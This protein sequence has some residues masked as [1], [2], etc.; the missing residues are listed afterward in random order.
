[1]PA[2]CI[3]GQLQFS[4]TGRRRVVA[5]F[6]GGTVSSDAGSQLLGNAGLLLRVHELERRC[7]AEF[8]RHLTC[9]HPVHVHAQVQRAGLR[10]CGEIEPFEDHPKDIGRC[11]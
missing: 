11:G 5:A 2:Q 7:R 10:P 6:C 8:S 9:K 1:M 4:C 3:A